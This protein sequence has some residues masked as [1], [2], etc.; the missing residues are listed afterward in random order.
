M[1]TLVNCTLV[2]GTGAVPL[3]D[4]AVVVDGERIVAI[5]PRLPTTPASASAHTPV[6][7]GYF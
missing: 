3:E 5:G 2:D 4:A 7:H 1:T 6:E